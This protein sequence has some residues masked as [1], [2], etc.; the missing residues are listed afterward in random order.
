MP[1][2]TH[3]DFRR[4]LL[5][6]FPQL[7]QEIDDSDGL[8][9]IEMGVFAEHTQRAKG[10]GDWLTYERCIKLADRMWANPDPA[11]LN[12]LNVS[13][14]EYLDF[15]GPRGPKAWSLLTPPLQEGWKAIMEYLRELGNAA[16]KR[17][18]PSSDGAA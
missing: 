13:Y 14:L 7:R 10:R 15:D 16:R 11:L 4:V 17:G 18:A 8:L 5:E 1:Q 3:H 12:A 9:H 2:L 6:E